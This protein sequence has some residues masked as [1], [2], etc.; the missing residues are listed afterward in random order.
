MSANF[1]FFCFFSCIIH[2]LP[3]QWVSILFNC[4]HSR[5]DNTM[6]KT[7]CLLTRFQFSSLSFVMV[8]FTSLFFFGQHNCLFFFVDHYGLWELGLIYTVCKRCNHIT[9]SLILFQ[10][11]NVLRD[12]HFCRGSLIKICQHVDE[13]ILNCYVC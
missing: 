4:T 9:I 5:M 13:R 8:T 12:S 11:A 7:S 2:F 1:V 6:K 10:G 3:S